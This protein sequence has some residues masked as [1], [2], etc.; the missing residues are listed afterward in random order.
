MKHIDIYPVKEAIETIRE[1]NR[2]DLADVILCL[3]AEKLDIPPGCVERFRITGLN[4]RDFIDF[5]MWKPENALL[6]I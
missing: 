6:P 1:F 5:E 2:L 3:G 4:N